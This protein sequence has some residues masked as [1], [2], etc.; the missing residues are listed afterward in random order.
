MKKSEENTLITGSPLL[1]KE[2]KE[3]KFEI[4]DL[5]SSDVLVRSG[6][7]KIYDVRY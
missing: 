4:S 1:P 2:V 3:H 7:Y 6:L 5:F